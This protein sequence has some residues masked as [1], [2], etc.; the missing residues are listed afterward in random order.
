MLLFS[1]QLHSPVHC[2]SV[3]AAV[4]F[5]L[6]PL[7]IYAPLFVSLTLIVALFCSHMVCLGFRFPNLVKGFPD[8]P[9]FLFAYKNFSSIQCWPLDCC[10]W[11][12]HNLP[13]SATVT[14]LWRG[15]LGQQQYNIH[16]NSRTWG[17]PAELCPKLQSNCSQT[18]TMNYSVCTDCFIVYCSVLIVYRAGNKMWR[19]G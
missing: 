19:S 9:P 17:F 18:P 10:V 8:Q 2:Q 1:P 3:S 13:L 14:P 11:V 5:S 4:T 7:S 15:L 12:L 6:V 16:M